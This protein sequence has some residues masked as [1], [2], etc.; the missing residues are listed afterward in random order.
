MG[1]IA[2]V[3]LAA[4]GLALLGLAPLLSWAV[5]NLAPR[6]TLL[7]VAAG[8][9][10]SLFAPADLY[11]GSDPTFAV[12]IQELECAWLAWVAAMGTL[13]GI[14]GKNLRLAKTP[15]SAGF[16]VSATAV[17]AWLSI[18]YLNAVRPAFYLAV[19]AA[20]AVTVWM[21]ARFQLPDWLGVAANTAILLLVGLPVA[22]L[23]VRTPQIKNSVSSARK[24]YSFEAAKQDPLAFEFWWHSFMK[25]LNTSLRDVIHTDG[26]HLV[27]GV[28]KPGATTKFFRS[29][30]SI[31]SDGFRGPELRDNADGV[32]RIVALGESTT[33]GFTLREKDRPWPELLEDMIAEH[34]HPGRAVEV[35]NAGMPAFTL[36]N[37]LARLER[38]IL[39]LKPDMIIAYHGYNGFQF[40]D[41]SIEPVS[42]A[43]PPAYRDRAVRLLARAEHRFRVL[44]F[45]KNLRQG[46]PEAP[47]PPSSDPDE[48]LAT[49]YARAYSNLVHIARES[50]IKLVL[51]NFSMAATPE[52]PPEVLE[53]YRLGFPSVHSSVR[54]NIL[55][56]R[57]LQ[58]I[59][60]AFPEVTL[61]DTQPGLDGN[62][63]LFI[64]L[65]HLTQE[66]RQ[67]LAENIYRG[68]RPVVRQL[69]AGVPELHAER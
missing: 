66:G 61:V 15:G 17:A 5:P 63:E 9:S 58:E 33:F 42:G 30:V 37:N 13:P 69:A 45:Q 24:L 46:K 36:L 41:D 2:R 35:V 3:P 20:V 16:V 11:F 67:Q 29:T 10:L 21:L 28:L 60:Q 51:C 56:S 44:V 59:G 14:L 52:S 6:T 43:A 18:A 39:P 64:D 31:N 25:E 47:A 62:H 50:G 53:F 54:A 57:L 34:L 40:L 38:D 49:R 27:P 26:D 19:P 48:L 1:W 22:D 12:R 68:V 32:L 23:V 8:G 4:L 55:H 7:I 65:V